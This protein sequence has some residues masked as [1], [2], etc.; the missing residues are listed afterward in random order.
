MYRVL[1]TLLLCLTALSAQARCK[2]I[3]LRPQLTPDQNALLQSQARKVPFGE[4]NH[5]IA[6]RG[7]RTIHVIGTMHVNDSRLNRIMRNLNPIVTQADAILLEVS[8]SEGDRFWST[9]KDHET[10]F[11]L[12]KGTNV[13]DMMSETGWQTL[14]ETVDDK[15]F[16]MAEIVKL[17]PWFLSML[18]TGSSCGPRGMFATNGLDNRIEKQARRKRIPVGSLETVESAIR[19]LS[20]QPLAD[21][22]SMLQFDLLMSNSNDHGF[23][24]TRESYFDELMAEAMILEE[25]RFNRDFPGPKSNRAAIWQRRQYSILGKRNKGWVPIILRTKGDLLIVA[26]GAAHLPGRDGILNLLQ[27]AGYKLERVNF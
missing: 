24:T 13:R 21:Q 6:T 19:T 23:V 22:V 4:G 26:V 18:L 17:K 27:R 20:N 1:L 7:S 15:Q 10:M 14:T 25:W 12:P 3:D 2:G 11:L 5:W 8:Q 16:E 9:L